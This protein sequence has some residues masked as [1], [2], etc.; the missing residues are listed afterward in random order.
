MNF[1]LFSFLT[2]FYRPEGQEQMTALDAERLARGVSGTLK[3][4]V[5]KLADLHQLLVEPPK[6]WYI[7]IQQPKWLTVFGQILKNSPDNLLIL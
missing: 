4:V 5:P 6:V 7:H 3:A 1:K 2:F